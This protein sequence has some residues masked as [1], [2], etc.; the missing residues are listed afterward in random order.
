MSLSQ[1]ISNNTTL[2]GNLLRHWSLFIKFKTKSHGNKWVSYQNCHNPNWARRLTL[3]PWQLTNQPPH[4]YNH[5]NQVWLKAYLNYTLTPMTNIDL[6]IIMFNYRRLHNE[7]WR[8]LLGLGS[9]CF[10]DL[11][12]DFLSTVARKLAASSVLISKL[13]LQIL[14]EISN[15]AWSWQIL[16]ENETKVETLRQRRD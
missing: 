12:V 16:G 2:L 14:R 15:V 9:W 3:Q 11:G 10:R 4:S 8:I 5:D 13:L 6:T 7:T 1:L